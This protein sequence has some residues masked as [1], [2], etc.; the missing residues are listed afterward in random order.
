MFSRPMAS[1]TTGIGKEHTLVDYVQWS[2]V[3]G[4]AS[5]GFNMHI[6]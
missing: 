5:L 1:E 2:E 3:R 6:L 4:V